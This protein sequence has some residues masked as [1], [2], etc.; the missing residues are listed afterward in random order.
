MA[1]NL[2][3]TRYNNG[4]N[5]TTD[6]PINCG[7]YNESCWWGTQEGA[8]SVYDNNPLNVEIYGLFIMAGL[9]L[10]TGEYVQ[11]ICGCHQCQIG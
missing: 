7:E 6:L 2:K 3:V 5:I 1:E 9:V 10:M 8:Y 4:D 11:K